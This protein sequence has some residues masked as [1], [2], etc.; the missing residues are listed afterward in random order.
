VG[1]LGFAE[2][3]RLLAASAAL[4]FPLQWEE[5]YGLVV[6]ESQACGT[7]VLSLNRGAIPE[8]VVHGRT[9]LLRESSPELVADVARIGR[10]RPEHCRA[11]AVA[12]LDIAHTVTGYERAYALAVQQHA[13]RR[14]GAR[15]TV[16]AR[17]HGGDFTH[18]TAPAVPVTSTVPTTATTGSLS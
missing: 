11:H 14:L 9:G 10:L 12:E 2:K 16:A 8:L 13:R 18:V 4:L 17:V 5:P 1:E 15:S 3:T 7:P 6:A